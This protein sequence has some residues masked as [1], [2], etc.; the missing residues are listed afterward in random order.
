MKKVVFVLVFSALLMVPTTDALA[1]KGNR[2]KGQGGAKNAEA[3]KA[4]LQERK[5]NRQGSAGKGEALKEKLQQRRQQRNADPEAAKARRQ[6]LKEKWQALRQQ[7]GNGEKFSALQ[8]K[9]KAFQEA[10]ESGDQNLY[11]ERKTALQQQWQAMTPEERQQIGQQIPELNERMKRLA[12]GG[13]GVDISGT[14]TG[15]KGHTRTY[16]GQVDRSGNTLGY[17]GTATAEGGQ[18]SAV[19]G[20]TVV[21]EGQASFNREW[22]GPKGKSAN[23]AGTHTKDGNV[24]TTDKTITGEQ[25]A[26]AHLT[27]T[28]TVEGN[29]V[30]TT[31]TTDSGNTITREVA[32]SA[33]ET[34]LHTEA[35]VTGPQGETAGSSGDWMFDFLEDSE[36]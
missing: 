11:R 17:E 7:G 13:P 29:T 8:E 3:I 23:V 18:Q 35:T 10:K 19:T 5:Q 15:P 20:T 21:K 25:G 6:A 4:R 28:H 30:T 2:A 27:S 32:G 22:K 34:G 31:T 12:E 26:D 14:R 24:I 16:E 9:I 33:D 1:A 36:Y